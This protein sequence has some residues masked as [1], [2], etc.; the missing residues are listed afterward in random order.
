MNFK[1][2]IDYAKKSPQKVSISMGGQ[3]N[4]HDFFRARMEKFFGIKFLRIPFQGGAPAIQA[5]AGGHV[6]S[7]TPFISEGL[8]SIEGKMVTAIA[9]SGRERAVAL[10]N[11]HTIKELGY[12][13]IHVSWRAL[14]L[15]IGVSPEIIP[16]LD[17]VFSKTFKDPEFVKDFVQAGVNPYFRPHE[18]FVKYYKE[19]YSQYSALLKE[20]GFEVK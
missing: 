11:V 17:G 4:S 1:Q 15:P 6:D 16:F 7:S 12:D 13:F 8:P 3:W 9:V 5:V 20:L 2:F 19:E 10:P 18:E 14:G